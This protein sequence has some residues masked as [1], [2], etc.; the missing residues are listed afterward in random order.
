MSIVINVL[1]NAITSSAVYPR[2]YKIQNAPTKKNL[3]KN[4]LNLYRLITA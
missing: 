3:K 4:L 2:K 1:E